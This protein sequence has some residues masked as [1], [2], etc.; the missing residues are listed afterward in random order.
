MTVTLITSLPNTGGPLGIIDPIPRLAL[1]TYLQPSGRMSSAE[2]TIFQSAFFGH[3]TLPPINQQGLETQSADTHGV[4]FG[5]VLD[6][7]LG[8]LVVLVDHEPWLTEFAGSGGDIV[9]ARGDFDLGCV[10]DPLVEIGPLANL[11]HSL[12]TTSTK[13]ISIAVGFG[14]REDAHAKN[15]FE[16][17]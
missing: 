2:S 8:T 3:G 6:G 5:A 12:V 15:N 9:V 7:N 13:R 17:M 10:A 1:R 4:G 14:E 16:H 11:T